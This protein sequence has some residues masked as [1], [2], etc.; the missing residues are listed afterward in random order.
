MDGGHSEAEW[1]HEREKHTQRQSIKDLIV[2]SSLKMLLGV[3][4][5]RYYVSN[6]VKCSIFVMGRVED[7]KGAKRRKTE[8]KQGRGT[9]N[10]LRFRKENVSSKN[11]LLPPLHTH[12]NMKNASFSLF[13]KK[14]HEV[15]ITI[16]S[17]T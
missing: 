13:I 4:Q 8:A 2:L 16:N 12:T 10:K 11:W 17:L 14:W 7:C 5:R 3:E 6:H 15:S 1:Y 9:G